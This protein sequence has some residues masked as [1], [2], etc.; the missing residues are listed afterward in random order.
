MPHTQRPLTRWL[1]DDRAWAILTAL[2]AFGMYLTTLQTHINGSPS[3][4]ATDVGELQ[5]AL[6]R[7]GTIHYSGYPLYTLL[8]SLFVTGLRWIGIEPAAGT[9]LFSAVWGAL[10]VGVLALVAV[11]L[12]APRLTA[13]LGALVVAVSTSAWIDASLAEV[14]TLTMFFVAAT[15]LLA[16]R[17]RR[18]GR[19]HHWLLLT[20]VFTQGVAHGR[21]VA[22]LAPAVLVFVWPQLATVR[23]HVWSTWGVA[24]L[25]P[26]TYLYL[27]LRYWQGATWTFGQPGTWRGFWALVLDTKADRIVVLAESLA[28]W[29]SRVGT[30]AQLLGDDLPLVLVAAGLVG[31]ALLLVRGQTVVGAALLLAVLPYLVLSLLIWEARISDALL[32]V[33]LPVIQLAGVGLALTAAAVERAAASWPG[34]SQLRAASSVVLGLIVLTLFVL[35]RPRVL[36]VTRDRSVESVID[37]VARVAPPEEPTTFFEPWG[38]DFWAL[39]YAQAYRGE[40]PGLNL[41]DHNAHFEAIVARGDRLLMRE[42]AFYT[43]PLARWEDRLGTVYLSSAAPQIVEVAPTPPVKPADVPAGPGLEL[44]NGVRIASAQLRRTDEGELML[45]VYWEAL[46]RSELDYSVAVHLVSHDPPRGPNDILAQA[47]RQ[48]PV[49][50]LYPTSRWSAGEIVRDDYL[51]PPAVAAQPA[52]VRVAMYRVAEDGGFVNTPWLTLLVPSRS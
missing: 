1:D 51:L 40:L 23:R 44:G 49:N 21:A 26:L 34:R 27:P 8:G 18:S 28:G 9:S 32:A 15:L 38:R 46:A 37:T 36:A 39:A 35:H 12:G 2:L 45:T 43:W 13:A 20:L 33:K 42:S 31:L 41:V 52:A 19:R 3:P 25:V 30:V 22:F 47:D 24:V 48:H 16:L 5:N 29:L 4:Y 6:P 14:H 7:W 10:A 11:E 50:G 17:F